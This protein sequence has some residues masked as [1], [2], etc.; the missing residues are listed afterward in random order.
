MAAIYIW[1]NL[2][3]FLLK[4]ASSK[5]VYAYSDEERDRLVDELIAERKERGTKVDPKD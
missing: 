4:G 2:H 1:P 5:R 3:C